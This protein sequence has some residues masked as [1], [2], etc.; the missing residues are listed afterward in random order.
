METPCLCLLFLLALAIP[1][2]TLSTT[3]EASILS[4][5]SEHNLASSPTLSTT[6]EHHSAIAKA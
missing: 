2:A 4:T 1:T 3:V 5:T 6:V